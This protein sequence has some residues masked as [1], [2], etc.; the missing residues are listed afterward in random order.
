M[1]IRRE[2]HERRAATGHDWLSHGKEQPSTIDGTAQITPESRTITRE[3]HLLPLMVTA[4]AA[5]SDLG[6]A[7]FRDVVMGM[8]VSAIRFG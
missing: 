4:G 7:V 5:G 2:A 8:T 1:R 6:K 3:E